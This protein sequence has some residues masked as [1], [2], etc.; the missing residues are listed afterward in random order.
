MGS[1][2]QNF[3]NTI[4]QR[5]GY[6]NEAIE[7]QDLYLDGKKK[8]AAAAVPAQLLEGTNLVGSVG[9]VKDRVAAYR[10]AGVTVLAINPVGGDPVK[11]VETLRTIIDA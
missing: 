7:I 8:E 11:T 3:Y 4:A 5:Y 1:R 9:Y 6:V 10:E 2:D